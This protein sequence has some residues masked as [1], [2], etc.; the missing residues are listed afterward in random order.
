[1]SVHYRDLEHAYVYWIWLRGSASYVIMAINGDISQCQ[2]TIEYNG[3]NFV[4]RIEGQD[5]LVV[6]WR[7]KDERN[8]NFCWYINAEYLRN[9][10]HVPRFYR[11]IE[12]R[13]WTFGRTRNAVGT[14]AAGV[15][16]HSFLELC[17]TFT[18]VSITR[19]KH[20]EHVFYFF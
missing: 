4:Q 10:K 2:S 5:E 6:S 14:L 1:M 19:L 12:T 17:Q 18:S 20:R 7:I 3:R 13:K 15:C 9:R 16:C 11:V 8:D